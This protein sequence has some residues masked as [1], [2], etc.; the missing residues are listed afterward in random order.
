MDILQVLWLSIE[1]EFD[2]CPVVFCI[3][4]R[5]SVLGVLSSMIDLNLLQ[6]A[7]VLVL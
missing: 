3:S 2:Q 1:H 6:E 7:S 5:K 4:G